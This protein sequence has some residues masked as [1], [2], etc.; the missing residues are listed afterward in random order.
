MAEI[1][2]VEK[3]CPICLKKYKFIKGGYEPSTCRRFECTY[4]FNHGK[5]IQFASN[6]KHDETL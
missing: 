1:V 6:M 2:W 5:G 4:A 3:T